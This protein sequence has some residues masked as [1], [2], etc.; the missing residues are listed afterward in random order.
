MYAILR[1][2][3]TSLIAKSYIYLIDNI[4]AVLFE[5]ETG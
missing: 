2:S 1:D 4:R 5:C 3:L